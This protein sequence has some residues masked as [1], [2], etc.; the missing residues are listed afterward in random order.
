[1]SSTREHRHMG[2]ST[3]QESAS[4]HAISNRN[5]RG[6]RSHMAGRRRKPFLV[7]RRKREEKLQ[8][9]D[10]ASRLILQKVDFSRDLPPTLLSEREDEK[11][12]FMAAGVVAMGKT[13]PE[14]LD[15]NMQCDR[16]GFISAT[17]N[18]MARHKR[19]CSAYAE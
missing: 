4:L 17:K 15:L 8:F 7:H 2:F 13:P 6:R 14:P 16:C 9:H 3:N 10:L 19:K 1:M 11:E 18:S 12:G 5:L